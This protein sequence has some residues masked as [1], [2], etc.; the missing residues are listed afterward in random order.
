MINILI[1]ETE[2]S[3]FGGKKVT[4]LM[5]KLIRTRNTLLEMVLIEGWTAECI[6]TRIVHGSFLFINQIRKE[7]TMKKLNSE[8][9]EDGK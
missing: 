1:I 6:F 2:S 9:L 5:L 4:V 3:L 8:R 7:I